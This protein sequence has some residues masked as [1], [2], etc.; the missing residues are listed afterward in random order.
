MAIQVDLC[1]FCRFCSYILPRTQVLKANKRQKL[2]MLWSGSWRFLV[3]CSAPPFSFIFAEIS[4]K[5]QCEKSYERCNWLL[6]LLWICSSALTIYQKTFLPWTLSEEI[7]CSYKNIFCSG[8]GRSKIKRTDSIERWDKMK[9]IAV[10]QSF[11]FFA[12]SWIWLK[13][14]FC[15]E[16]GSG[17]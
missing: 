8:A 10:A 16:R 4:G 11:L 14:F 17:S 15:G 1:Y 5:F 13:L 2:A 6:T 7:T 12:E 9:N 3:N